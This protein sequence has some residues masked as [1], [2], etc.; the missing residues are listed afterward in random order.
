MFLLNK[1]SIVYNFRLLFAISVSL[2]TILGA[3]SVSSGV[4][5]KEKSEVLEK[6]MTETIQAINKIKIGFKDIRIYAIT[7]PT[8]S[9]EARKTNIAKFNEVKASIEEQVAIIKSN[10]DNKYKEIDDIVADLNNYNEKFYK[11]LIPLVKEE[12][13]M[14]AITYIKDNLAPLGTH[15]DEQAD[16][17]IFKLGEYTKE[18]VKELEAATSSTTVILVAVISI[19]ITGCFLWYISTSIIGRMHRLDKHS[20]RI[21]KG[22]LTVDIQVE[23]SDEISEFSTGFKN[24]V[25][26]LKSV[27]N[28]ISTDAS[29]LSS[30]CIS[31]KE[32]NMT[33]SNSCNEVLSQVM[34]VGAASEEMVAVSEEISKNCNHAATNAEDTKKMAEQGMTVVKN[35]VDSIRQQS[36]KTQEDA[37]LILKLGEQTQQIDSIISTIQDIAAQ[38]NLLALNAA[39]E[40]A[41]AGE[42]GRGFA[43]VADEVRALAARTSQS[44]KE[45]NEMI[46]CVQ[47]DVRSANDSIT[48]TVSQMEAVAKN[49]EALQDTLSLI[50]GKVNDVSAQIT[51]IA[52]ATEEQT[53]TSSEMSKNIQ[54]ITEYSQRMSE[55]AN[56]TYTN[57][58][59]IEDLS[60]NMIEHVSSFKL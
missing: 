49:A 47:S 57:T 20:Q 60:I 55:K 52:T 7:L 31:L 15:A 45:I 27:I 37:Q 26:S 28:M 10:T 50:T 30:S 8:V 40:A 34:S 4:S 1:L 51:Q 6:T 35:T 24:L 59:K 5:V 13:T 17:L 22:D 11:D 21:S 48:V 42:H 12:K 14:I 29:V 56:D 58:S 53:A 9:Q 19:I 3:F 23:G 54:K 39:I 36:Q 32:S 38:T 44:T 41:R 18:L 16:K 2:L 43:V 46:S 33:I 25:Q